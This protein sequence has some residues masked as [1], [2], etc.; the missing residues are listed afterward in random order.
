M[1]S[2]NKGKVTWLR[3]PA[4]M[5][6]QVKRLCT[7]CYRLYAPGDVSHTMAGYR[8]VCVGCVA[9]EADEHALPESLSDD[10]F[11]HRYGDVL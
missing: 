5:R 3:S 9:K 7:E 4:E 6:N 8:C 10:T 1:N 11:Q 2:W